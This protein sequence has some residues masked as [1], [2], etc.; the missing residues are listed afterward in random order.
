[1]RAA[2][3]ALLILLAVVGTFLA[4]VNV[5]LELMDEPKDLDR[6]LLRGA[7]IW[8]GAGALIVALIVIS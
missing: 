5:L 8:S 2:A 4:T 7:A 1:M 6:A 3:S